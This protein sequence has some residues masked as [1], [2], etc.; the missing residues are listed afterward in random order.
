MVLSAPQ[1][2]LAKMHII[3]S[4][5]FGALSSGLIGDSPIIM[6]MAEKMNA[7]PALS[8]VTTGLIPLAYAI[9][10]LP[11]GFLSAKLGYRRTILGFT[12]LGFGAMLLVTFSPW[13]GVSGPL[14]MLTGI[15]LY[16][17][18]MA[19]Y[20]AAWFPFIDN[21]LPKEQRHSFFGYM[22]FSWQGF[23]VLFI[24]ACGL[25]IGKSPSMFALQAVTLIA[26]LGLLGRV[27]H[28][29]QIPQPSEKSEPV[30]F[31]LGLGDAIGNK[32]LSGYSVYLCFLYLFCFSTQPLAF[33]YVKNGLNIPANIVVIISA[34]ALAGSI[35]GF[36]VSGLIINRLK[37]RPVMVSC[38]IAFII[39]NLCLFGIGGA[40]A[41][42][43][44]LITLLLFVNAFMLSL[45]SIT[46]TGEMLS[47][48]TP[49]NRAMSMAYC[50]SFY[51][52]GSGGARLLSSLILGS[53]MLA[54]YWSIGSRVFTDY[55]TLFLFNGCALIFACL[56]LVIVPAVFPRG[57]YR[58][59]I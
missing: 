9:M 31:L 3:L 53:G 32:A 37:L 50:G 11:M 35:L 22:R 44:F 38:H 33:I 51:S 39:I 48:S 46:T 57:S 24:F 30:K 36:L 14:V 41:F 5:C 4:A 47:L 20:N 26:T 2:N 8:L 56:L 43:I 55:Q 45:V 18:F 23:S 28:V 15:F 54:P 25:L 21:I 6:I 34:L 52:L 27:F 29:W 7:G 1:L 49:W 13:G 10:L 40:G 17:I 19:A 59:T 58:Y 16:G 12:M 42:H